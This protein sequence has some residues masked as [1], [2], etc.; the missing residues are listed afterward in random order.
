MLQKYVADPLKLKGKDSVISNQNWQYMIKQYMAQSLHIGL[1]GPFTYLLVSV[2]SI[3]T[4]SQ[5]NHEKQTALLFIESWLVNTDP[6]SG[7]L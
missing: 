5:V 4:Y 2:P 1:L 7:S 3:L 6:Y